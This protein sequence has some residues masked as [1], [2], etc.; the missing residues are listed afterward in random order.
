MAKEEFLEKIINTLG[1][2]FKPFTDAASEAAKI[3]KA[4]EEHYKNI[5]GYP[6]DNNDSPE[7]QSYTSKFDR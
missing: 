2:L 3:E 6:R 7:E 5:P 4:E 1:K